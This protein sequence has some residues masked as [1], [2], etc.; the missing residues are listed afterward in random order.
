MTIGTSFFQKPIKRFTLGSK[1]K[2]K[3]TI[4]SGL[5][6]NGMIHSLVVFVMVTTNFSFTCCKENV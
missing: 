1:I 3:S 4:I 6:S 2:V 5:G